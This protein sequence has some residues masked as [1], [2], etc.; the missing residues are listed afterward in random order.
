MSS[1]GIPIL[2]HPADLIPGYSIHLCLDGP[3]PSTFVTE[4]FDGDV[5][6]IPCWPG[7][8][9]VSAMS[10]TLVMQLILTRSRF[11]ALL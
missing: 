7:H 1:P 6:A 4:L 5:P 11:A 8:N 10:P 9:Q 3:S 2:S